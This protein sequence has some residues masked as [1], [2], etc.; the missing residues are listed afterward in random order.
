MY[1]TEVVRRISVTP[2]GPRHGYRRVMVAPKSI[3]DSKG[4][5]TTTEVARELGV[6]RSTVHVWIRRKMLATVKHG[7]FHAV[8]RKEVERLR[9]L[10]GIKKPDSGEAKEAK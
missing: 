5:L 2:L 6:H 3:T 4:L 10:L 9:K 8:T 1:L 7:A